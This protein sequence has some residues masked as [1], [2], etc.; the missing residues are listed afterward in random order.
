MEA[1]TGTQIG[2]ERAMGYV[3]AHA[4]NSAEASTLTVN[5]VGFRPKWVVL[6]NVTSNNSCMTEQVRISTSDMDVNNGQGANSN[7]TAQSVGTYG[8]IAFTEN[9]F[10]AT[11]SA[12]TVQ[13]NISYRSI[14]SDVQYLW[15]AGT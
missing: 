13:R 15:I 2:A 6:L 7:N 5:T 10:T 11:L 9:G 3:T 1:M 12:N 14:F 8:D 4:N